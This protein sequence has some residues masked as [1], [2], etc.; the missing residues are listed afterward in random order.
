LERGEYS[1]ALEMTSPSQPQRSLSVRI[2]P[3][4]SYQ[5]LVIAHDTTH[6][7]HL[8]TMRSNF[9]ANISHELRTP[10]TVLTG[11]LET[12]KDMDRPASTICASI[13]RPC[14][15]RHSA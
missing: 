1:E 3:F 2:I 13:S 14:T 5:K 6:L 11:F 9:V 8:E 7:A 12:L 4:G 15:I 10:L